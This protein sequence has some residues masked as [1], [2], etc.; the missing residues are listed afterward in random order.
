MTYET[1][2]QE[3]LRKDL[4]RAVD[5]SRR[6]EREER[7]EEEH[8]MGSGKKFEPVGCVLQANVN[9]QTVG[10]H[11]LR[12]NYMFDN[13]QDFSTLDQIP[14]N[15]GLL[16]S[17]D[18]SNE[19]MTTLEKGVWSFNYKVYASVDTGVDTTGFKG[20]LT[21]T[22]GDPIAPLISYAGGFS[23]TL[24]RTLELPEDTTFSA[25]IYTTRAAVANPYNVTTTLAIV[26]LG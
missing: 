10:Q 24:S 17:F 3:R 19:Y 20:F 9:A 15:F 7:Y 18:G 8:G 14:S 16:F 23:A 13:L 5:N 12:W 2:L 1:S 21:E 25:K 4:E 22:L 11:P 26:R 6:Q